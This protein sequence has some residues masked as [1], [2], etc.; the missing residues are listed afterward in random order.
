MKKIRNAAI[1]IVVIFAGLY[2]IKTLV[3]GSK[4][5]NVTTPTHQTPTPETPTTPNPPTQDSGWKTTT[6]ESGYFWV[7]PEDTSKTTGK[8][9]IDPREYN[10]TYATLSTCIEKFIGKD[11]EVIA[12]F[13][14]NVEKEGNYL[15][16]PTG[17]G[18]FSAEPWSRIEYITAS[19]KAKWIKFELWNNQPL[20]LKVGRQKR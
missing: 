2:F 14:V 4:N 19:N 17:S 8:L 16:T 11:G 6:G 13:M 3:F 7:T 5:K 15:E 1:V 10:A 9:N 20:N 12:S 18:K